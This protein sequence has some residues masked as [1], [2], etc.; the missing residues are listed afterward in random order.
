MSNYNQLERIFATYLSK[1][2]KIKTLIKNL[3]Q[4]INAFI[5]RKKYQYKS[6][7]DIEKVAY[8]KEEDFFGYYDKSPEN[9]S[10]THCIFHSSDIKTTNLPSKDK[11][12]KI[13]VKDIANDKFIFCDESHAY[14]WQQGTKLQWIDDDKFIFNSFCNKKKIYISK[15]FN[16]NGKII[17]IIDMPIYDTFKDQY[18]L[19]L[20]FITLNALRPDYGYRCI[21][22]MSDD[23]NKDGVFKIDLATGTSKKIILL[24][25]LKSHKTKI[26]MKN[27]KHK[28]N[29]IMIS[30]DG[31]HFIFLHR[32]INPHGQRFDRLYCSD[33]NGENLRVLADDELVS[34]FCWLDDQNIISYMRDTSFGDTFYKINIFSM[35]ISL[36]STKLKGFSDGHPSVKFNHMVFD[37]YP[38]RSRM[39]KLFLFSLNDESLQEIGEFYESTEYRDQTRCDLHPK[40]S[41]NGKQIYIDSV[42]ENKRKLYSIKIK[43]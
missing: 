2:P 1:F 21:P 29:H 39:K 41:E 38:N 31:N 11:S 33:L 9:K 40:W 14:N 6:F 4:E 26:T 23:K 10:G 22:T 20:N 30:P 18:A 36:L 5:F 17:K 12:I 3:Y 43:K 16:K 13:Y 35:E 8:S 37:T 25:K 7:F 32:W 42:H 24:D 19:T 15:I 27:A 28:I 34:H